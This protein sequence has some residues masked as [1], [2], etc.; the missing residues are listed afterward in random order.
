MR[1]L[2]DI[3][4]IAANQKA[5]IFSANFSTYYS[6]MIIS[7]KNTLNFTSTSSFVVLFSL[8]D[9]LFCFLYIV[10]ENSAFELFQVKALKFLQSNRNCKQTKSLV[11]L[12]ILTSLAG[13][14][15]PLLILYFHK[16]KTNQ[17]LVKY[18]PKY[19]PEK[20]RNKIDLIF[21]LFLHLP[22]FFF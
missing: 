12:P 1:Q 14:S 9:Y 5:V 15:L 8:Y 22:M 18:V 17:L 7:L 21:I 10:N 11:D 19:P 4:E 20:I 16:K 6:E 13:Y 3:N 2:C